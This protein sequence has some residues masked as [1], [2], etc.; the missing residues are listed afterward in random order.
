MPIF[1][2]LIAAQTRSIRFGENDALRAGLTGKDAGA[3]LRVFLNGQAANRYLKLF[4]D[5]RLDL[6]GAVPVS[7]GET[8]V[9][10]RLVGVLRREEGVELVRA[11]R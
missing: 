6:G 8:A 11:N 1:H 4:L 10:F 5:A 3:S 2:A 7:E 9:D